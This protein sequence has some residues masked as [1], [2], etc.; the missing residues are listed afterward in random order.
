MDLTPMKNEI[1]TIA[2][3]V[4][5]A[6]KQWCKTSRQKSLQ[7]QAYMQT[8]VQAQ[9]INWI[10]Y[11]IQCELALVLHQSSYPKLMPINSIMDLRQDKWEIKNGVVFYYYTIDKTVWEKFSTVVTGIMCQN[12]NR[13]ILF[14]TNS[15]S[16]NLM[17]QDIMN[18][19][20]ALYS[21][22]K[23]TNIEDEPTLIRLVVYTNL[24]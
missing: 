4:A 14:Y 1:K 23:I 9:R 17:Q 8:A 22:I 15:L 10:F 3:Q 11:E 12:M 16:T 2:Q 19:Y 20:P 18:L 5:D 24:K 21:G 6:I 13:D 7:Q